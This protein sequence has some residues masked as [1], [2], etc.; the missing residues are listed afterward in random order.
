[1]SVTT[2]YRID[3]ISLFDGLSKQQRRR[4]DQLMTPVRVPA[5]RVLARQGDPGREFLIIAHGHAAVHRDGHHIAALG[6]GDFFG[7]LALIGPGERTATVTAETDMALNVMTRREFSTLL[8]EFP[9]VAYR[10]L[11]GATQRLHQ[12][13]DIASLN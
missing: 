11:M 12:Q 1:M 8:A 2:S 3:Q 10:I 9:A 4:V 6:P 13:L 7:E 5:G